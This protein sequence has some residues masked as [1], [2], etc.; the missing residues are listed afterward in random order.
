M[1]NIAKN[2]I[3]YLI[4][5]LSLGLPS[6]SFQLQ[7][8]QEKASQTAKPEG[9]KSFTEFIIDSRKYEGLFNLYQKENRIYLEI[10]PEQFGRNYLLFPTLWTSVPNG[11]SRD[12]SPF[13]ESGVTFPEKVFT[14]E[15]VDNKILLI[16]KNASYK[17]VKSPQ[18]RRA[19][20]NVVPQ[21]IVHIFNIECEPHPER[22]SF[23]IC[24]DE[25]FFSDLQNLGE[26]YSSALNH[27]YAVDKGRTIWGKT[28]AF[29]ENIELGVRYTMFSS[30]KGYELGVPDPGLFTT[31][32]RYSICELPLNN[33][34][35][36]RLADDR[37]GYFYTKVNDY[38]RDDIDGVEV[39]YIKRWNLEKKE[40]EAKISEPKKPIIFW[41]ENTVPL[42]YRKPLQEG[43]L[44]W[45]KAFEKLGF[46][47]AIVVKQMPDDAEWDSADM[48]YNTIRWIPTFKRGMGGHG[49]GFV[50][51]NPFTGQILKA[52]IMIYAPFN[53]IFDYNAL[54]Y[55][56]NSP[57]VGKENGSMLWGINPFYQDNLVLEFEKNFG[58]LEML[59]SSRINNIKDVPEEF[60]YDSI[61]YKVAHEVG[62]TL[63]LR[64]NFKGSTT[65]ALQDLQNIEVTRKESIGSSV[66]DYVPLNLAPK[67]VKQGDY[68]ARTLGAYDYWAIEYGYIPIEAETPEDELTRLNR[69]ASRSTDPLL[70]FGTDEDA[71]DLGLFSTSIDPMCAPFDLSSDPL[72]YTEQEINRIKDIWRQLEGR[73]L[74]EG[75]SYEY[76]RS[77]F[78]MSLI[79]Y[80]QAISR[81]V[82]WIGGIYHTRAHVGDP[83]KVLPF[84]VVEYENQVRAF[85]IINNNLFNADIFSFEPA[86]IQKLQNSWFSDS[87]LQPLFLK[88]AQEEGYRV[89]FSLSNTLEQFYQQILNMLLDPMRLHRIQ[90]NET[91]TE[92]RKLT[93]SNY[94][95]KLHT[96]IWKELKEGKPAGTY[97]RILQ[98]EY[99]DKIRT[100]VK[101]PSPPVGADVVTLCRYQLKELDKDIINYLR[102]Y[103][104][105]DLMTRAHFEYCSDI[106][107]QSLR[108]DFTGNSIK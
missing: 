52:D 24:L 97:R 20:N 103:P 108:T 81:S 71:N 99:L 91:S 9:T 74:F 33:G 31:S 12:I 62:H 36:P 64:H 32:V 86:F 80:F 90:D 51:T 50:R 14:W 56:L 65:I 3:Y 46:K 30:K 25:C 17:T 34:Y 58:I 13:L 53:F 96:A 5:F 101:N 87:E 48:R 45:N 4:L 21:S 22:H 68:E 98:K 107:T 94:F 1:R 106:I 28:M 11:L 23:L 27:P 102:T 73:T 70:T 84:K 35:R 100:F 85:D 69:I 18:L 26:F 2:F 82:K 83:G 92:G 38:D 79:K 60:Y 10:L 93:L 66:M 16:W 54:F 37:I 95:S 15:K 77:A 78:E 7:S 8:K 42:E 43:A 41:L 6:A 47:N 75:K 104:E 39:R 76:L 61:R 40:P 19:L 55:P 105:I 59:A 89:D 44:W 88:E 67:G 49:S 57:L 29:P 63:G 72:S